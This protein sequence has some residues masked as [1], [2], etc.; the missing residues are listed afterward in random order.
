MTRDWTHVPYI[1][2][3]ILNH[4]TT[5]EVLI[6]VILKINMCRP[7][8]FSFYFQNILTILVSLHF[9]INYKNSLSM[10]IKTPTT[11]LIGTALNLQFRTNYNILTELNLPVYEYGILL[12]L[13]ICLFFSVLW[14]LLYFVHILLPMSLSILWFW[15]CYKWCFKIFIIYC[16]LLVYRNRIDFFHII[17][18][19]VNFKCQLNWIRGYP[20]V[21]L[22]IVSGCLWR[23][24]YMR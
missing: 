12:L 22:D 9:H 10:S 18:C 5:R 21:W 4:W 8:F 19:D 14:F 7:L 3:Q 1:G 17:L 2:R 23:F 20:D 11:I 24:F 16:L 15:C 13:S 6:T